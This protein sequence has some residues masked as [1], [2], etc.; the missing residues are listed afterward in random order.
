MT[1]KYFVK[2][3]GVQVPCIHITGTVGG[4]FIFTWDPVL[5][6]Y[7]RSYDLDNPADVKRLN[8]EQTAI[9]N[10]FHPWPIFTAVEGESEMP[11]WVHEK[12]DKAQL[13]IDAQADEIAGLK[14]E[15]SSLLKPIIRK[16]KHGIMEPATI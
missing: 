2:D 13:V 4:L 7:A 6:A 11:V 12:F 14:A 15:L 10:Q 8:D 1:L 3:V 9:F 16:G 5:R